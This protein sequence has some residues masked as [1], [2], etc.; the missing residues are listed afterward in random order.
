MKLVSIPENEYYNYRLNAMFDCYKWDPQFEDNNTVAKHVLVISKEEHE[1]IKQY[2]ENMDKEIIQAE[3]YLKDNLNLIKPLSVNRK[4]KAELPRMKNYD[5]KKHIRLMR[6]DFHPVANG[7]FA[8]SEV[9]SD[10]PGGFAE[11]TLL[12]K[13]AKETLKKAE[14]DGNYSFIKFGE[15]LSDAISKKVKKNGTIMMV[16]CTCYSDDRQVMQY[17]GDKLSTLGFKVLY[18]AADHLNFKDGEAYSVLDGN[19]VKID[20]IFRFT[21]LEWLYDIKPKRWEGY[22]DTITPSCNHPVAIFF[23]TKKFPFIFNALE[24][25]G[26]KFDTWKKLM[27]ETLTV[28]EAKGKEG[29]IYKPA[30]GRV[31]ERISIKEACKPDEYKRI[32]MDVKLHPSRYIAQKKFISR[33]IESDNGEKFHVC[34]GSYT[35]EGKHAGYYARISP[36]PRIDSNAA[37]IPVLIEE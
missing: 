6:Y 9:N 23:Q 25:Q 5:S 2:T 36:T 17:L 20:G 27:P 18:G 31:G 24:K 29:F 32:L 10:V 7:D 37:D 34:L 26:F 4:I 19:K 28:R 35:V 21:P 30:Y 33:E 12:P 1:K 16:H 11:A 3:N 13:L 22:F 15:I 14:K 8:V